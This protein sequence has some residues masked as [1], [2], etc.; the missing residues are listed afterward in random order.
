M[1]ILDWNALD[2]D[3]QA[4]ALTRPAQAVAAQ[5]RAAVVALIEQVRGIGDLALR[6]ITARLDGVTLERF[7]VGEDEFAGA[8]LAVPADLRIAMQ[9]AAG[10]IDAYHRAGMAQPYSLETAP[11]VVCGKVI[12]PIGR[13]GLYV[14]A[15]SAPL[16]STALMLGV[17]AKLAGCREVVLCTPP[18]KDGT[19]DPAVLVAARLT[20]VHKVFKIGGAQAIAAMAWG[21]ATVP[22]C[23]KLFGPGNSYVTEAKQ[24]VAQAGAAAIDMPAGPSEV[25]VIADAGANPAFV[26][27]DL[28]SQA[29]H[30][31][32][33]Q[34]LLLSDDAALIA[35][36]QA[37]VERQVAQLPRQGIARQALAASLL[38][39]VASIEQAFSI[40]NRYAPEHLILALRQPRDWLDHV[41][42]AGSVFLGDHTPEALGDYCSGTNHV[43]PTAG[44]A[45]AFSGVS[46]ASFQNQISVQA[47]SAEGIAGIGP[48]ALIMARAE[49]LDAHANAVALRLGGAP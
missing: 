39:R 47:A 42:A 4:R 41:E 40:S 17:P 44:A 45:R 36:V 15:G 21:T 29:E 30:G 22:S 9:Q 10:R 6:D 49:G 48:C 31:P 25:L 18:R 34:V 19:A 37:E 20:G 3:A 27:A 26:A 38:V 24:Q 2:A 43:L 16:P 33:S 14:P 12:R 32:D 35:A 8:E 1:N 46:V 23:D 13:V 11:G 7:E 28:L 5:T